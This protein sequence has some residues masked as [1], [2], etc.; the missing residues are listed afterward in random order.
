[1]KKLTKFLFS[2]ALIASVFALSSCSKK[3]NYS[4]LTENDFSSQWLNGKWQFS[5]TAKDNLTGRTETLTSEII[6]FDTNNQT[7]SL[8]EYEGTSD[9]ITS[10]IAEF[11]EEG[12]D[13][14][15]NTPE[16][17]EIPDL[18]ITRDE[19]FLVTS[20]KKTIKFEYSVKS[21][22]L[23]VDVTTYVNIKKIEE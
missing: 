14:L 10:S 20:D 2:L 3:E 4:L 5:V 6:E 9:E 17:T 15:N 21:E 13:S 12:E 11:F 1:M 23:K 22:S 16:E 18:K 8:P 7:A 19:G